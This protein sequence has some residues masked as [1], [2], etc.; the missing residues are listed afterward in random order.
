MKRNIWQC[1]YQDIE[2]VV[3]NAW[4]WFG[5]TEEEI[6]INQEL[7]YQNAYSAY[8]S[9][10]NSSLG[11]QKDF[12]VNSTKITIKVGSAWNLFTVA[13]Q[14]LINNVCYAGDKIVLFANKNM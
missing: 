13:C 9:F 11:W 10:G 14:I 2:I 12:L 8:N 6:L 4:N 5:D 7:V 3:K 1:T